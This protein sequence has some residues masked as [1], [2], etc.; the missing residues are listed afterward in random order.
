MKESVLSCCLFA[1]KTFNNS[2]ADTMGMELALFIA[3]I[4]VYQKVNGVPDE[5]KIVSIKDVLIF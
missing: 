4:K 5:N 1:M 2:F 3:L